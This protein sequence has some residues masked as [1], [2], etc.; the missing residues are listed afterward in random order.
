LNGATH[1]VGTALAVAG[2]PLLVV[3]AARSGRALPV[4][5]FSV[6]GTT[7]VL[8]YLFSTLYHSARGP[9]KRVLQKLDHAAIFLLIAGTYTPV[10]LVSL[11]GTL[12]WTLFGVNWGL[13]VVGIVLAFVPMR[14]ARWVGWTLYVVMGW[15]AVVALG[16]LLER[17]GTTGG[18]LIL[19]GGVLYTVGFVFYAWKSVPH[20]HG[21]FHLLVMGGSA[22]HFL[23]VLLFVR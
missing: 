13:A 14:F 1:L 2:L 10:A 15:L 12:G 19:V 23:A 21:I 6:Y 22:L 18:I 17:L 5:T 4:V 16:P 7:L 8:L 11:G 3:Q 9:A 20:H